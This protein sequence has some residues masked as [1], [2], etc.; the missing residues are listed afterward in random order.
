MTVRWNRD[1]PAV[2]AAERGVLEIVDGEFSKSVQ[3]D[4]ANLKEGTVIY[5]NST[6]LV[7]FRLV[8]FVGSKLN[9]S[10]TVEWRQ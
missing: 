2:R 6:P 4:A 1:S 7:Q 8:I 3:L 9:V 5:Q 10:E